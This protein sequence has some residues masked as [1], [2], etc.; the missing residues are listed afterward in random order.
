MVRSRDKVGAYTVTVR[1]GMAQFLTGWPAV[2]AELLSFAVP[3]AGAFVGRLIKGIVT[4]Q[5]PVLF[6]LPGYS[7]RV[8]SYTF[9]NLPQGGSGI[10]AFLDYYPV[11]LCHVFMVSGYRL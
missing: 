6:D 2:S 5:G 4:V 10:Q 3:E 9:S 1:T 11:V 8:F 7:G